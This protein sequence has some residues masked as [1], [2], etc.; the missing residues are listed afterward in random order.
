MTNSTAR[1]TIDN[2]HQF[3]NS[4]FSIAY[5]VSRNTFGNG[6]QFSVDHQHSMIKTRNV[7]FDNDRLVI[8]LG[9]SFIKSQYNLL[10][11]NK[12][13]RDATSMVAIEWFHNHRESKIFCLTDRFLFTIGQTL[14]GGGQAK[15]VQYGVGFFFITGND[16]S[17]L[18]SFTGDCGLY[19]ALIFPMTKLH[20][21]KPVQSQVWNSTLFGSIN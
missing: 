18:P 17:N 9:T 20:K 8:A 13:G 21:A 1:I 2:F 6:N 14:H 5:Y 19:S 16:Y 10:N 11:A 12:I 4:F 7:I 3:L 15:I